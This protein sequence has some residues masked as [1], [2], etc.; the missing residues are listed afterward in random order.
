MVHVNAILFDQAYLGR[1]SEISENSVL[2]SVDQ[3]LDDIPLDGSA[4][5]AQDPVA[6]LGYNRRTDHHLTDTGGV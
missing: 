4:H 2:H 3:R 5:H 1:F 6:R